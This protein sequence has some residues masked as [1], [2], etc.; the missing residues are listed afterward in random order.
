M[1]GNELFALMLL[2]LALLVF[3]FALV[4]NVGE[5]ARNKRRQQNTYPPPDLPA[6]SAPPAASSSPAPRIRWGQPESLYEDEP[7][8]AAR[9]VVWGEE[10]LEPRD[11]APSNPAP[12]RPEPRGPQP[13]RPPIR[14]ATATTTR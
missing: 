5:N 12:S 11:P 14:V 3:A 10:G 8:P 13:A 6:S 4:Y 1:S 9:G 7:S 2:G